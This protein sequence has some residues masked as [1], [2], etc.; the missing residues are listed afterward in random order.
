MKNRIGAA[1][2]SLDEYVAAGRMQQRQYLGRAVPY[3]F[4][5][6][7]NR[8]TLGLPTWSGLRDGLIWSRFVFAPHGKT[9]ALALG[10]GGFDQ[11][12]FASASGSTT[13]SATSPL[14]RRRI[15]HDV[16]VS[17]Q[18]REFCQLKPASLRTC[19]M[20]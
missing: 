9:A 20:V 4:V 10:I 16:P 6:L 15:R 2:D 13:S 11:L 17:H 14:L 12:F 18:E 5:R 19:Q 8:V 1:R 7:Q 3:V